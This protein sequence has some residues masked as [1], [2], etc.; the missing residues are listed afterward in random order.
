M[1]TADGS[2]L[3]ANKTENEDLYFAIRGGGGNF[4]VVTEFVF[5]LHPQR[6]TIYSGMLIYAAS[7]LEQILEATKKWWS[8]IGQDEGLL[9]VTTVGPDGNVSE[10]YSR[11]TIAVDTPLSDLANSC[12]VCFLQRF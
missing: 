10:A 2:V 5:Q 6:A 1:V 12:A 9:Q 7:A 4:G 11:I 3:T 8:N